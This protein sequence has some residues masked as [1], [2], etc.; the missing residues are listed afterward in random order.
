MTTIELRYC[1]HKPCG[2][3][4]EYIRH[5]GITR[6]NKRKYCSN[7]CVGKANMLIYSPRKLG[8][9][10]FREFAYPLG[11]DT[12][13]AMW[14]ELY[15]KRGWGSGRIGELLGVS[16]ASVLN[17]LRELEYKIKSRGGYNNK[18][19]GFRLKREDAG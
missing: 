15:V 5:R 3:K 10:W 2:K 17:R 7:S 9:H 8:I 19:G 12:E 1:Q 16:G 18:V 14:D 13:Q 4:I 11:Y 6:H